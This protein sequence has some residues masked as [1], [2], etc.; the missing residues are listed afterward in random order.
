MSDR[1]I[2]PLVGVGTL[3]LDAE[4]YSAGLAAG[5]RLTVPPPDE[6][7]LD[8][9]Q[10]AAVLSLPVSWIET[11]ARDGRIPSLQAGRWRRFKRSAVEAALSTKSLDN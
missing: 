9:D 7:V 1:V 5:A 3:L 8:A 10:L 6:P 4:T 2:I 11:A